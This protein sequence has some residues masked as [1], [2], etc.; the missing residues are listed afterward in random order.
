MDMRGYVEEI[1]L[2]ITGGVLQLEIGDEV[3]QQI[4]TAAMR[5]MQR[6]IC[7][8]KLLTLPYSKCI[9]LSEYKINSI[10][11]VYRA[12]GVNSSSTEGNAIS[13]DS[14]QIGLLQLA[15]NTGNMYNLQDYTYNLASYNTMQQVQNTMSTDLAHFY[16]DDKQLLYINSTLSNGTKVTIEYVPRY[17][18]VDEIKSDFWID[19]LMRLST[20]LTKVALGRVRSRYTQS[21]ALWQQDGPTL[22]QEGQ[23]ELSE[24]RTYLQRNTRYR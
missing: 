12:T 16:E 14:V 3:I 17:D 5:E 4:V 1:K 15:F 6:Y 2:N 9:D 24:L 13:T 23:S 7:S 19:V 8:T 22:L 18:S 21:N 10:S 20:A 11:R